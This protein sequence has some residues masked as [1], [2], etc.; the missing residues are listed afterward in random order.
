MEEVIEAVKEDLRECLEVLK[1]EKIT[2]E[3]IK[4]LGKVCSYYGYTIEDLEKRLILREGDKER[5][6]L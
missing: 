6:G 2:V 4:F 3:H 5:M 1:N